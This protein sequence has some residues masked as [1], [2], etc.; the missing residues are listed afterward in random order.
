MI[1]MQDPVKMII[2]M[3]ENGGQHSNPFNCLHFKISV[4]VT[5][6]YFVGSASF[7]I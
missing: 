1:D 5:K 4:D 6:R 3:L 2:F 7:N